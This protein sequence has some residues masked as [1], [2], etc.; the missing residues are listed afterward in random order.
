MNERTSRRSASHSGGRR[1]WS[2]RSSVLMFSSYFWSM[3]LSENRYPLF[4][5]MFL[6]R[7]HQRPQIV[8]AARGHEIAQRDRPVT[9]VAE[10][11][12]PGKKPQREAVQDVLLGEADRAVHLMGDRHALLRRLGASYF[13]G[14]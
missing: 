6:A 8:V 11:V 2:K 5:I 3:M 1:I 14:R 9:L 10:I 13:G 12:A 4:G 7:R